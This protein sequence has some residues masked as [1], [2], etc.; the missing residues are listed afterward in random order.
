M[1]F[2]YD[3]IV[4]KDLLP[5]CTRSSAPPVLISREPAVQKDMEPS[6][7]DFLKPVPRSEYTYEIKSKEA[8]WTSVQQFNGLRLTKIMKTWN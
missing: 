7:S 6:L 3:Q 1:N 2:P 4:F 5:L 8:D